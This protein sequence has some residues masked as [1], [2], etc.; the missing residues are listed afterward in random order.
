MPA[1]SGAATAVVD[2]AAAMRFPCRLRIPL[3][4]QHLSLFLIGPPVSVSYF[5]TKPQLLPRSNFFLAS[6]SITTGQDLYKRSVPMDRLLRTGIVIL[7]LFTALLWMPTM[8]SADSVVFE[9]SGANRAGIQAAVDA[10]RAFLGEPNN[11]ANPPNPL[12]GRREI[13]WDA[14]PDAFADPNDLP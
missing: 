13:N 1:V 3:L 2:R 10:F 5:L 7:T 4:P 14:V 11:Q 9:A 6:D 8:V 12:G